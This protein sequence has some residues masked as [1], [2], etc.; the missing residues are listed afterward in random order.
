MWDQQWLPSQPTVAVLDV[1]PAMA[2]STAHSRRPL[3]GTSSGSL[4]SSQSPSF[5]WDQQWLPPQP[6]VA[7]LYVGPAVAPNIML[8]R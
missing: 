4:R 1:G 3:R 8:H 7:V 6:T 5:T 2:P